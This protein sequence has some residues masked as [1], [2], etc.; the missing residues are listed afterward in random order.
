MYEFVD[1]WL[2]IS[3]YFCHNNADF[4]CLT[5]QST[6]TILLSHSLVL[7]GTPGQTNEKEF[8]IFYES[9]HL[10]LAV[11]SEGGSEEAHHELQSMLK[12]N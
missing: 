1:L 5:L 7:L 3:L 6:L 9:L 4:I 8:V 10:I 12:K 2:P 11:N